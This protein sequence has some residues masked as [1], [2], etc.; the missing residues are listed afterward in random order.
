MNFSLKKQDLLTYTLDQINTFFPD[1]KEIK[2]LQINKFFN[3][4]L[5][6]VEH[7][8]SK[9]NNKY[10][11]N[12]KKFKF[13]HLN[14]DH[15]CVYLYFLSNSLYNNKVDKKIC[16]KTYYLNKLLN[17]IDMFYEVEL[18]DIFHVVHP[19][20]TILGRAKYSNFLTVY[21][22]CTVG[23]NTKKSPS[24]GKYLTLRPGSAILGNSKVGNN[25]QMASKAIMIDQKLSDNTTYFGNPKNFFLKRKLKQ[26]DWFKI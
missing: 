25:C 22:N 11:L 10:Y 18:P 5:E 13:N 3:Y 17:G 15:Y 7:C 26:N 9:V 24:L 8:L 16:E 1:D 21:Q 20:G 4:T 19:L 6:R 2:T 12:K 23:S 14:S